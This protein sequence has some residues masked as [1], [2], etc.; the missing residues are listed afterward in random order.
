[1]TSVQRRNQLRT[2]LLGDPLLANR[3]EWVAYIMATVRHETAGTYKPLVEYGGTARAKILY[4]DNK[5][6]A[7]RLGNTQKGDGAKFLGRGYVQITGRSNY[8]KYAKILGV[9]L[10]EKPELACD[11]EIAYRIMVD[12]MTKGRFTGKALRHYDTPNGFDFVAARRIINGTDKAEK[13]A[14]YAREELPLCLPATS[15]PS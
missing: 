3:P 2:R 7:A 5:K 6:L 8:E 12:G 10:A 9:P 13:I 1:M 14:G 4:E 11:P 15:S